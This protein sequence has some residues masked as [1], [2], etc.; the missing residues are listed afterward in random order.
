MRRRRAR[1]SNVARGRDR[2][3]LILVICWLVFGGPIPFSGGG[4]SSRPVYT[5]QTEL[6]LASPV[7]IA[8][9][10]VGEVTGISHI[11]GNS[12][13]TLV[14][15]SITGN[16]LAD[17]CRRDHEDPAAAVSGGQLLR[18][19]AAG[20]AAGAAAVV[21]RDAQL[22]AQQRAGAARPGAVGPEL[23]R[24]RQPPDACC[25]AS[26]STL[27]TG[28]DRGAGR[29][30]GPKPAGTDRRAV[31]ERVAEVLGR[32][33]SRPRRSSTRRCSASSRTTCPGPWRAPRSSSRAWPPIR[34]RCQAW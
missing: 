17:P 20:H 26:G 19:P 32:T 12:P 24:P 16:G 30:P 8:G 14:T 28:A 18:R 11:G 6:H 22:A 7:R 34:A 13:A 29:L 23:Q 4:S 21:G 1:I 3:V 33:R 10:D 5:S 25:R 15:M 31:A 2:V 27:N 9:V